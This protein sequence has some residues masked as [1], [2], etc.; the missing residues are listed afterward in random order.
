[1]FPNGDG[2]NG[3]TLNKLELLEEDEHGVFK[4]IVLNGILEIFPETHETIRNNME[5][6]S[7]WT[8]GFSWG[9]SM[10]L[11]GLIFFLSRLISL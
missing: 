8:H 4:R 10:L 6:C 5:S 7:C 11:R 9:S 2:G 1:M 3:Q